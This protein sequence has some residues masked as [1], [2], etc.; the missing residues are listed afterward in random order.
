MLRA[1]RSMSRVE[2]KCTDQTF[3]FDIVEPTVLVNQAYSYR[4]E[5]ANAANPAPLCFLMMKLY[6]ICFIISSRIGR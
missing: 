1:K 6:K 2:R 5:A 3:I 4:L